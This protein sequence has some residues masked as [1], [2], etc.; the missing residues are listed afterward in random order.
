MLQKESKTAQLISTLFSPYVVA[1]LTVVIVAYGSTQDLVEAL[2]WTLI[3]L[4]IVVMPLFLYVWY[5]VRRGNI[6]DLHVRERTQRHRVYAIGMASLLIVLLFLWYFEAPTELL[7]LFISVLVGN[8]ISFII[9]TRWKISLHSAGMGITTIVFYLMFG[10][11][12]GLLMLFL[13]LAVMWSRV[14]TGSHTPMQ[15]VAGF[16]VAALVTFV[17]FGAFGL[18]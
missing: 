10:A 16:T 11:S 8:T 14:R 9:N 12:F 17:I 2:K 18:T 6:T 15:T 1:I 3:V 4:A 7:A 5:Q 13:S